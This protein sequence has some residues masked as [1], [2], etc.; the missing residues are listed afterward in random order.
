MMFGLHLNDLG[1][2]DE[3][4]GSDENDD[5]SEDSF[6]D[7]GSDQDRGELMTAGGLRCVIVLYAV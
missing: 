1:I 3:T 5:D 4:E 6:S 2:T 7:D